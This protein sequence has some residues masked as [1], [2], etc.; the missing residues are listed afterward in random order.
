MQHHQ[1]VMQ[2]PDPE[3]TD[4][5]IP[6]QYQDYIQKFQYFYIDPLQV[7]DRRPELEASRCPDFGY[8]SIVVLQYV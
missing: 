3:S 6:G 8:V 1:R 5:F 7:S 4:P 2:Q